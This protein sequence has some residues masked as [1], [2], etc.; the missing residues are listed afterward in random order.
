[1][2]L[3]RLR[4]KDR[5]PDLVGYFDVFERKEGER[6]WLPAG[7]FPNIVLNGFYNDLFQVMNGT[8]INLTVNALALGY[9]LTP[10]SGVAATDRIGTGLQAEWN[11]PVGTIQT[12][13][14]SGSA[15][16]AAQVT[17]IPAIIPVGTV[18]QFGVAGTPQTA[19]VTTQLTGNNG[20]QT[21]TFSAGL[22]GTN[23]NANQN[24][25]VG[26]GII[27]TNWTPQRLG[28]TLF[29]PSTTDPPNGVW[30]FYLAAAANLVAITFTEAGLLYKASSLVAGGAPAYFATHAAFAYTK[31]VNTDLRVDYTLARSLT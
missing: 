9:G 18:V 5:I 12:Q 17:G 2:G 6:L 15:Y 24:Y 3:E 20:T 29:T 13:L 1:M 8:A 31:A 7:R 19:T 30:S 16:T 22:N 21:L 14:N 28:T 4:V 23:A 25:P 26:T 10:I 27:V 11:N